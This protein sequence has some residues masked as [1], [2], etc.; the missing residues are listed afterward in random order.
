QGLDA[1][2]ASD[3]LTAMRDQNPSVR[4]VGVR[5]AEQYPSDPDVL[6]EYALPFTWLEVSD[7]LSTKN[8]PDPNIRQ[9]AEM[10]AERF[11]SDAAGLSRMQEQARDFR[12]WIRVQ[13]ALSLPM[14]LRPEH[15]SHAARLL[16][17]HPG[18]K[19]LR[20]AVLSGIAGFELDVLN[21]LLTS[22]ETW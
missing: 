2:G 9:G 19:Y 14:A 12:G 10:I 13:A 4:Q 16:L 18:E 22:A 21:R 20:G 1:L 7:V 11:R 3:V 17:W 8:D 5:L 6:G 15:L